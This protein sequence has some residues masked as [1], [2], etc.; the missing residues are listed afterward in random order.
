MARCQVNL[1]TK[2]LQFVVGDPTTEVVTSLPDGTYTV[3]NVGG[4]QVLFDL[5]VIN[6]SVEVFN[7]GSVMPRSILD[8]MS[9]N[10]TYNAG[11]T[12]ISFYT[13]EDDP[14]LQIDQMIIIH[15]QYKTSA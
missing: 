2:R 9:Y 12:L 3:P 4:S 7:E 10:V 11:Q 14:G 15:L 5:A 6:D 8:Q 1:Y 13:G